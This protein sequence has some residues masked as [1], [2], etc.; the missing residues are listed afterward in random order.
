[1]EVYKIKI[2]EDKYSSWLRNGYIASSKKGKCWSTLGNLKSHISA[3]ARFDK[4]S[5]IWYD[6]CEIIKLT[7]TGIEVV[8]KVRDYK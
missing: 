4:R 6:D 3:V 1:M 8:G 2:S 5:F 7:E